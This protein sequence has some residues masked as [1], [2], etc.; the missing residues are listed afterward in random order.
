MVP[1]FFSELLRENGGSASGLPSF[2][3]FSWPFKLFSSNAELWQ[4]GYGSYLQLL[5]PEDDVLPQRVPRTTRFGFYSQHPVTH[6]DESLEDESPLVDEVPNGPARLRR[7]LPAT[8][9]NITNN[10]GGASVTNTEAPMDV[11]EP[12][13][14]LP[15]AII[16]APY[17]LRRS[18]RKTNRL[19]V[20]SVVRS[21]GSPSAA[22][23]GPSS[24]GA[25]GIAGTSDPVTRSTEA[26][27]PTYKGSAGGNSKSHPIFSPVIDSYVPLP[28]SWTKIL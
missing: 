11:D 26:A 25:S 17:Y 16:E 27:L 8:N 18:P 22:V 28:V 20:P 12:S 23:P 19:V 15:E 6:R 5:A 4:D 24:S 7:L 9:S 14:T 21:S 1:S 10:V 2:E 13:D 3:D